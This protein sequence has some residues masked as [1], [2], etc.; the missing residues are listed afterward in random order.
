MDSDITEKID[1]HTNIDQN[2]K[3]MTDAI[4]KAAEDSTDTKQNYY[5]KT[6]SDY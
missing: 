6:K 4:T 2:V 3:F 5:Y 1:L